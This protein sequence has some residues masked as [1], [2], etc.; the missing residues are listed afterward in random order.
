VLVIIEAKK[1]VGK[2]S[3]YMT[4]EGFLVGTEKKGEIF[5]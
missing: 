5:W 2:E 1:R 4:Q 3:S